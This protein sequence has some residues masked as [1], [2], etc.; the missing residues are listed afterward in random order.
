[1]E[2]DCLPSELYGLR[3]ATRPGLDWPK[4]YRFAV[5]A[6]CGETVPAAGVRAAGAYDDPSLDTAPLTDLRDG[7]DDTGTLA[8]AGC[9]VAG[10][11]AS[12]GGSSASCMRLS[13]F[14]PSIE[15]SPRDEL[16]GALTESLRR[17]HR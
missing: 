9:C 13:A 3:A 5:A 14:G 15:D 6:G 8:S 7:P 10:S 2:S 12:T 11:P 16:C 1:M 17:A 4:L